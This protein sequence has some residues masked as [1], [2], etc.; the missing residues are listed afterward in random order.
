MGSKEKL[1]PKYMHPLT[2]FGFHRLFET[3]DQLL[4][5]LSFFNAILQRKKEIVSISILKDKTDKLSRIHDINV[6]SYLCHDI[7]NSSFIVELHNSRQFNFIERALFY[8]TFPIQRQSINGKMDRKVQPI[9]YIG[10]LGFIF[11]TISSDY[12]HNI[13]LMDQRN[14]EFFKDFQLI[15]IELLKFNKHQV[16]LET[17]LD[18]WLFLLKFLS[19][20]DICPESFREVPFATALTLC[21]LDNLSDEEKNNYKESLELYKKNLS[22]TQIVIKQSRKLEKLEIAKKAIMGGADPIF[23]RQITGLSKEEIDDLTS[24]ILP[25]GINP[26]LL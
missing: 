26:M 15:F 12:F 14:R 25:L 16:S 1:L 4:F 21:F 23:I 20:W 22:V 13:Q 6:I 5:L 10:L 24:E 2:D 9:Y 17:D 3:E 11:D 8:S 19:S 7:D 18:K